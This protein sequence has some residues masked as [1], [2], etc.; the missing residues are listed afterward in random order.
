MSIN[1]KKEQT[2][3]NKK[4]EVIFNN[5]ALINAL[6]T[7]NFQSIIQKELNILIFLEK[8]NGS[9]TLKSSV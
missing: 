7:A 1:L 4:F 3:L 8:K 6:K 2:S 9:K 5:A